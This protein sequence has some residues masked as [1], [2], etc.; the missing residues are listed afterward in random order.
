MAGRRGAE[1][2]VTEAERDVAAKV[3][4]ATNPLARQLARARVEEAI[5]R[6]EIGAKL[7]QQLR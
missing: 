2:V 7:R 4:S 6:D 1:A 3:G 5:E